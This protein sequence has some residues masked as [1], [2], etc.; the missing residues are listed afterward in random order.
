[1]VREVAHARKRNPLSDL[2]KILRAGRHRRRNHMRQ[3]W[4]RS[5]YGLRG[6]G[7]SKFALLHWLWS[8]PLQ[9]SRTTVRVCDMCVCVCQWPVVVCYRL[10]GLQAVLSVTFARCCTTTMWTYLFPKLQVQ[11]FYT[12]S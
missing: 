3:F 7:G 12:A 8:S 9:H 10:C 6:G 11:N 4:W 2:N 1:M 5:V